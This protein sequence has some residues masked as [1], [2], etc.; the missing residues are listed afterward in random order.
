MFSTTHEQKQS[1]DRGAAL[2]L[3]TIRRGVYNVEIKLYL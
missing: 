1:E 2:R 3:K